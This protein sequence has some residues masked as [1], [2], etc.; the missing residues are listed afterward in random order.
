MEVLHLRSTNLDSSVVSVTDSSFLR[1]HIMKMNMKRR[2]RWETL[3]HSEY[4]PLSK[5][6]I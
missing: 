5:Y 1:I 3:Q 4:I 2:G 6:L